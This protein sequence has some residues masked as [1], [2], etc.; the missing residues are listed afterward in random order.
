MIVKL[1]KVWPNENQSVRGEGEL[2][3]TIHCVGNIKKGKNF[4]SVVHLNSFYVFE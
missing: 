3:D 1:R 4:S 2:F